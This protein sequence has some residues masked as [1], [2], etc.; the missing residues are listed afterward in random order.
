MVNEFALL[1]RMGF[2][3]VSMMMMMMS[4]GEWI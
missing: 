2:Q 3:L 1:H 4:F